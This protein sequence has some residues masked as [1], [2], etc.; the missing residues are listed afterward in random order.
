MTRILARNFKLVGNGF[1]PCYGNLTWD[2]VAHKGHRPHLPL[3]QL[4]H[5]TEEREPCLCVFFKIKNDSV[6]GSI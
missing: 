6:S 2:I 3:E 1:D 5:H 4:H